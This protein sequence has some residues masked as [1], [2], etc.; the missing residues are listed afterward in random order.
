VSL[1]AAADGLGVP[2]G[3][4]ALQALVDA[5]LRPFEQAGFDSPQRLRR[6]VRLAMHAAKVSRALSWRSA[7]ADAGPHDFG[8]PVSAWLAELLL[9]VPEPA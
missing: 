6:E 4:P 9:D 1:R 5:Y 3:D 2:D 7:L 8:D